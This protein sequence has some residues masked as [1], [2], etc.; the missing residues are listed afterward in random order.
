M[1]KNG[2]NTFLYVLIRQGLINWKSATVIIS[3]A[4]FLGIV[5]NSASDVLSALLAIV[6]SETSPQFP[7]A[8]LVLF[9]TSTGIMLAFVWFLLR[10]MSRKYRE[11]SIPIVRLDDGP[12]PKVLILFV[13]APPNF[14]RP[15]WTSALPNIQADQKSGFGDHM[16]PSELSV[17]ESLKAQNA[18]INRDF[19]SWNRSPAR[20]TPENRYF[21]S[22][23]MPLEAIQALIKPV[24]GASQL[25]RIVLIPS[26]DTFLPGHGPETALDGAAPEEWNP[27]TYRSADKLKDLIL[28]MLGHDPTIMVSI[29]SEILRSDTVL[30]NGTKSSVM[31]GI[32]FGDI[33]AVAIILDRIWHYF[34]NRHRDAPYAEDE[35]IV[36]TTGGLAVTSVAAA[37]YTLKHPKRRIMYVD[38][39]TYETKTY[40]VIHNLDEMIADAEAHY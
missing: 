18:L 37:A 6:V 4:V 21:R 34:T 35:I 29:V 24:R 22:W 39:N 11:A 27:G 13:S 16:N 25:K 12:S 19:A 8:S 20:D 30:S 2:P 36:D 26:A 23:R 17:P 1:E 14:L 33:E 9:V 28:E 38:T 32:P 5:G 31:N 3:L 15:K 10:Q 7:W 40:N